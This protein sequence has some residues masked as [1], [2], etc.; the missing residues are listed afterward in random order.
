MKKQQLTV[1]G[2]EPVSFPELGLNNVIAKIDT[3][4]YS[5][6]IHCTDIK[7]IRR[8]QGGKKILK[9]TPHG[10][11]DLAQ[12]ADVFYR[13]HVRSALGHRQKR[14]IIETEIELKG[15]LYPILIGL[16]NRSEMKRPVL[17]GRRFLRDNNILV[18]VGINTEYD[19][20]GDELI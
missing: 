12:E 5:G 8:R 16:S 13:K 2:F 11:P 6:A 4:A 10:R 18:D 14:Y 7:V 9:F 3:G 19:E 20:E 1:G 17:L 15:K